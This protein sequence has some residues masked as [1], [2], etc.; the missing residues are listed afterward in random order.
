MYVPIP[1]RFKHDMIVS[2]GQE[3]TRG[4]RYKR[5]IEVIVGVRKRELQV[6]LLW[7]SE[8]RMTS[9]NNN[10]CNMIWF[11]WPIIN[12]KITKYISNVVVYS[13]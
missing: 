13:F 2:S 4:W 10:A 9:W 11:L 7:F 6:G 8:L 1:N 12:R 5:V 3:A